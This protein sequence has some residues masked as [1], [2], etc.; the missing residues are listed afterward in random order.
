MNST[1]I[2]AAL[3]GHILSASASCSQLRLQVEDSINDKLNNEAE[4]LRRR[5]VS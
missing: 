4:T 2:P 1:R 5:H 3:K